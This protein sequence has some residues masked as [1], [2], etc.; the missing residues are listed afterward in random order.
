MFYY[1]ASHLNVSVIQIAQQVAY[2]GNT[3]G[4]FVPDTNLGM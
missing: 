4:N 1:H 2:S 3:N